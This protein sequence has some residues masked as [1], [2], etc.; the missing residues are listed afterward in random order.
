LTLIIRS[1][2]SGYLFENIFVAHSECRC[3]CTCRQ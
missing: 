3:F 1:F 2:K